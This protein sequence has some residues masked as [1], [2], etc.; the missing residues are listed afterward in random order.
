MNSSE[1]L[2]ASVD[3]ED[4][5]IRLAAYV[6][7]RA[8]RWAIPADVEDVVSETIVRI[9]DGDYKDWDPES[10]PNF[11]RFCI[12]VANGILRNLVRKAY[13]V[14]EIPIRD[15]D[16]DERAASGKASAHIEARDNERALSLLRERT[17][18]D[19]LL[20][21]VLDHYSDGVEK[22]RHIAE[23]LGVSAPE[24]HNAKR[25]LLGHVQAVRDELAKEASK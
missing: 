10:E 20:T 5:A 2:L 6:G 11:L 3:W 4:V 25:R 7:Y 24:V 22:T 18:N 1:D 14:M 16:V 19:K 15:D 8:R 12:S 13:R 23:A 21:G 17:A 9:I